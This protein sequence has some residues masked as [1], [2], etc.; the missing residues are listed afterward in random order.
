M[1]EAVM[2]PSGVRETGEVIPRWEDKGL[3]EPPLIPIELD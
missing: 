1:S 3:E 2:I